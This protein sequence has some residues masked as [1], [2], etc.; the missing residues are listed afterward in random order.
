[1]NYTSFLNW[2]FNEKHASAQTSL[3]RLY[4][5]MHA[6]A[7]KRHM[8]PII[9]SQPKASTMDATAVPRTY[10]LVVFIS[11]VPQITLTIPQVHKWGH[12][13]WSE[14]LKTVSH[15]LLSQF[16]PLPYESSDFNQSDARFVELDEQFP[17]H[18]E[19]S[20]LDP[21]RSFIA[22]HQTAQTR[23]AK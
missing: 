4:T 11:W 19:W 20:I 22:V 23:F 5:D 2:L 12:F 10:Y 6:H 1:M 14:R 17:E 16:F 21:E 3:C 9:H 7:Y 18:V 15:V 13:H 8:Q